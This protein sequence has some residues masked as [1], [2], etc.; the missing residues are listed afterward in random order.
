MSLHAVERLLHRMNRDPQIG[1]AFMADRAAAVSNYGLGITEEERRA[2]TDA[3][4]LALYRLGV[5]P[6]LLAPASRFFSMDQRAFKETLAVAVGERR[7]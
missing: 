4:L 7:S 1:G 2:L 3:D 5:H 6:L